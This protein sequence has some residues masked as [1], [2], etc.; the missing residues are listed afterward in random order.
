MAEKTVIIAG[1]EIKNFGKP[2]VIAE[3][4]SNHN[5]ELELAKHLI[6]KAIACGADAVKFQSFDTTLFSESC[7]EGDERRQKL[8]DESPALKRFFTQVHPELKREMKTYMTPK[9][10]FRAI[11]KYCDEKGIIFFCTPLDKGAVDFC[12]DEL[13]MP[14]IKVASMDLNNYPF[15]DY[16]AR[17]GKP[18]I[19]STGMSTFSEIVE[20]VETITKAGNEQLV[21]LHCVSLYPPKDEIIQLNNLDLL[22]R[23]FNFPI[24]YSDHSFGFSVPLAAIAK[25]ACMIEKHFTIDKNLPG[26]DH[27]V[28]ATPFELMTIVEEGNKIYRALGTGERVVSKEELEK[29]HLFRR[30]IVVIRNMNKGEVIK[31]TDLDF[32]RPGIGLEPKEVKHVIGRTL[33]NDLKADDL[34]RWEDLV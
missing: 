7:Y 17:K 29:R 1:H 34:V 13:D 10:M 8:M 20:A 25:G 33:K 27:K 4:G 21:I 6:D 3:I 30:S 19:L 24:G 22:R 14:M 31:E 32:R 16:L 18:L 11:K 12:V 28:S 23:V 5:G 26:W 9:E 15:L 2:F